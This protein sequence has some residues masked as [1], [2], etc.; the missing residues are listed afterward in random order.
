MTVEGWEDDYL[1]CRDNPYMFATGVLG[2]LPCDAENPE[3][4]PQLEVWQSALL[5]NFFKG[6]DS[7]DTSSPRHSVRSGH[8]VGKTVMISILALWFVLTREDTKVVITA[9]SQPQLKTNNWPELRKWARKLPKKLGDQ[10]DIQEENAYIKAA[11]DLA[12][13]T[14]RTASASNPEAL[15]G[16]HAKHVLY[17]IDEA[18]GIADVVFEVAQGSLST[19]GA[20]SVVFSNPTKSAGFFFDTHHKLRHLY[21][22]WV[23][24]SEDV[25]RARGHIAEIEA[26]Y[27]KTS[28]KYRVRVLGQFPTKDDDVVI[29]LAIMEAARFR[30]VEKRKVQPIW[31]VDVARFGD[32]SSALAKRQ[33]NHLLEPVKEWHQKDT[34]QLAGLIHDEWNRTHLAD[35]PSSINI[36]II[37]IGSG[38]YDRLKELKLPVKAINVSE[39]AANESKY[40]RKRDELWFKGR[41]WFEALNV[42]CFDEALI[43]ELSGPTF[44]FNSN[45]QVI[46]E[47]K[48]DM[49]KRGLKS[50]NRGDA[51][52]N[53]FASGE[54]IKKDDVPWKHSRRNTAANSAWTS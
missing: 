28:N 52:L 43:A 7:K 35:K 27:G 5:K 4:L 14:R 47:S 20:I 25:P 21:R 1:D 37:G 24:N 40:W 3:G 45:G 53:T 42:K 8:G 16:I 41:E 22:G 10:I 13:I 15:Q 38:V 49:K 39:S 29:G 23:V 17:L 9:N 30:D 46:V 2:F 31:G 11:P 44:D 18:S 54:V 12:F 36:D 48:K 32:D 26:T 19:E 33:G 50:P 6:P 34:M 51:F